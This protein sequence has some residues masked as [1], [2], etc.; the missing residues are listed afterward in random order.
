[1]SRLTKGTLIGVVGVLIWSFTAIFVSRL[2]G[3]YRVQPLLLALYELVDD[4]AAPR[5]MDELWRRYVEHLAISVSVLKEGFDWHM[6][7]Q[8]DNRIEIVLNLFAHG[9]VER[10]LDMVAGGVDL[11]LLTTDGIGLATVALVGREKRI[12]ELHS[13]NVALRP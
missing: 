10:G 7:H 1:M 6:A 2:T 9:P 8:A 12:E 3:Y 4:P 13:P 11:Y 5:T